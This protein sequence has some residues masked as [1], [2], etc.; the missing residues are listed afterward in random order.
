MVIDH[1]RTPPVGPSKR[2]AQGIPEELERLVLRCLEKDPPLRPP[3][4][5]V[6]SS[7]RRP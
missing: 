4:V 6:L 7:E 1:V 3:S 2:A 5:S